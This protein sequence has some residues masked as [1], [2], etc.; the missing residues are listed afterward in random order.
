MSGDDGELG[1]GSD[2]RWR[3]A[4]AFVAALALLVPARAASATTAGR[5]CAVRVERASGLA[6]GDWTAACSRSGTRRSR[7]RRRP[8]PEPAGDRGRGNPQR[9]RLLARRARRRHLQLRRRA[10][11]RQPRRDRTST[12]RSSTWSR[13]RAARVLARRGRRRRVQLRRRALPRKPRRDPPQPADRRD[14]ADRRAAAGTGSSRPTAASS[15]SATHTST[16]ASAAPRSPPRSPR[17]RRHRTATA[18]GSCGAT[19]SCT[20]S[21]T[22]GRFPTAPGAVEPRGRSRADAVG[23]RLLD[24]VHRR[25]RAGFGDA[26]PMPLPADPA[27]RARRRPRDTVGIVVG[28]RAP[29][30]RIPRRAR[31]DH[32]AP[33][34]LGR[35]PRGRT[36]LRRRSRHAP[37][38]RCSTC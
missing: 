30:P 33:P 35:A 29:L 36:H 16:A 25:N 6:R 14:G 3:L 31:A 20:T 12:S 10:L 1:V 7:E 13:H 28:V 17:S 5:A 18:T 23:E 32:A 8:A 15:A 21:A 38:P 4:A 27:R 37:R 26:T 9:Q 11:P 34:R 2:G 19:A 24:R 22:P